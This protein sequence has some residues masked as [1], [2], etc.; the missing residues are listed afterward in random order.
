MPAQRSGSK[1]P[2]TLREVLK[3]NVR[4]Q[5]R[6]ASVTKSPPEAKRPVRQRVKDAAA[7]ARGRKAH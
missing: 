2:G 6:R 4:Q 5:Q 1:T 7:K 3:A